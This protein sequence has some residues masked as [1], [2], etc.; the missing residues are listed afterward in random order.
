MEE[1]PASQAC[2]RIPPGLKPFFPEYVFEELD[3]ERHAFTVIERTLAWGDVTELRWLFAR[4][5]ADRL[6]G[7]VRQAGW[8]C[9][10]RRRLK[11]WLAF[12]N[13][14]DY[15]HGERVWPH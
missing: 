13:L 4:Y 11:Y 9:L 1:S 7:W 10:P 8:R 5:G 15:E 14:T 6:A 2:D 3:P 12:F